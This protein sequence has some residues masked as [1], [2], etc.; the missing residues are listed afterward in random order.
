MHQS[1]IP[2]TAES[3]NRIYR[4]LNAKYYEGVALD[5]Y[6][7]CEWARIPHFYRAFYVYQY[8]TG[9][10]SAVT[11]AD[12]ILNHGGA[13]DYLRFLSTGGSDYPIEELKIAGVDLTKPDA[14]ESAMRVFAETMDEMEQAIER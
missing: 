4:E 9:F 6:T 7:D 5:D 10:C 3:L 8:S 14:L 13:E 1:G 12:R 2:L 11:I